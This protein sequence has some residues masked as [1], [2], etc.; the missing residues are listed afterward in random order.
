[1]KIVE[2]G[3]VRQRLTMPVCIE[4]M[5][6]CPEG[7]GGGPLHPAGT[8][9]R[10]AARWRKVWLYAAWLGDCFGA[11]VLSAFPQNAGTA[12]P[13]HL[14]YVMLFEAEHGS[15]LGM[16]DAS[17]ITE[18]RTVPC[19]AWPPTCWPGRT[20]IAWPSSAREPGPL[21]SG[22]HDRRAG[23]PLGGGL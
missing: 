11:K 22:R 2:A 13:S 7:A 15:F 23:H 18:V 8:L 12:Y 14:G 21:S 6:H 4:L 5:R 1:M 19:P 20:P 9:H 17:V 3:E 16:A 10:P